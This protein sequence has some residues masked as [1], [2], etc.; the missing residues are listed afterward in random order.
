MPSNAYLV[1]GVTPAHNEQQ[2]P[3]NTNI[4]I[5]FAKH[6]KTESLHAGTIRF[7]KVN[8]DTVPYKG[9]YDAEKMLYV[10]TPTNLLESNTQYQ[11]EIMG[12]SSG[13]T[14][15]V[16]DYLPAARTYEFTTI[17]NKAISQPRNLVLSQKDTYIHAS[18]DLPETTN[19]NQTILYHLQLSSSQVPE[20]PVIWKTSQGLTALKFSIPQEV[21]LEASYYVMVQAEAGGFKSPWTIS[22]I[23][24]E[25]PKDP[26][27]PVDP[28]KPPVGFNQLEVVETYPVKDDVIVPEGVIVAFSDELVEPLPEHALYVVQAPYKGRLSSIDKLTTYNPKNAVAGTLGLFEGE[29]RILEWKPTEKLPI[30]KEYTVIVSK[31][32]KGKTQDAMGIDYLFGFRTPWE[33][34]YGNIKAI[35]E[36][37]EQFGSGISKETLYDMLHTNS[38]RAYE[39]VSTVAG[40]E[41]KDYADGKAPY[42]VHKW[43]EMQTAYDILLR[44]MTTSQSSGSESG[45]KLGQL[46]VDKKTD[47]SSAVSLLSKLKDQLKPWDDLIHGQHNRGYAKPAQVVKGETGATYPPFFV[48]DFKDFK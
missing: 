33:R 38:L 46:E 10:L 31:A 44:F 21:E 14:S 16:G 23:F 15:V 1:L 28:G 48:R 4:A 25:K 47:M 41:P 27:P 35:M 40:F 45:I 19:E 9:V 29:T 37:L 12:T 34:M 32:L 13:I 18:W 11:I 39:I 22:Q 20:S 17:Q 24:M 43:V 36:L 2:V 30:E 42:Y 8:G 3:T 5:S 26:E 7:R 6:M